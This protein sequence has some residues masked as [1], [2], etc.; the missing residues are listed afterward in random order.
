MNTTQIPANDTAANG[1]ASRGMLAVLVAQFL[2]AMADNLLFV[3]AIAL[4]KTAAHGEALLPLLQVV[5]VVAFIVLA[6]YVGPVA[7]A[8]PKGR[9]MLYA[10]LIKLM[11]ALMILFGANSLLGYAIAGIGAAIYSPA[12]YGILTQLVHPD[13]LV[14]ANGLLEGST[15][16]AI[17]LGVLAGG[18]LTDQS[19][20]L[21]VVVSAGMYLLAALANLGIPRLPVIHRLVRHELAQLPKQ[22]IHNLVVLW[23]IRDVRFAIIGTSLFWGM[24]ASLR[25]LIFAWVPVALSLLDNQA[26]ANLMGLVSIGIVVGAGLAAVS[27]R[28]EQANRA[29]LGGL[30]LGPLIVLLAPLHAFAPAAVILMLVGVAGGYFV[31]PLNALLQER[32]HETIGAGRTLAVQN[33]FENLAM[34]G[35]AGLYFL[36]IEAGMN[37]VAVAYGFGIVVTLGMAAL[38]VWRLR[39]G[40]SC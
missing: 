35:M 10:N 8:F 19:V 14:K 37:P 40:R 9:V 27:V 23:G 38:A 6:P 7:D 39:G 17:L 13:R 1:L 29:I 18:W 24:G 21:A 15:I 34:L 26:P 22:F 3:A 33:F 2:S 32:G 20:V 11:G 5:F 12:K 31:V 30:A 16:A 4:L 36:A 28:L 25:L